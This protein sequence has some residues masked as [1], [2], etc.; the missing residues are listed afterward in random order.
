MAKV[1]LITHDE[2]IPLQF[3]D[4]TFYVRRMA[5]KVADELREKATKKRGELE[6]IDDKLLGRLTLEHCI[7]DWENLEDAAGNPAPFNKGA[8]PFLPGEIVDFIMRRVRKAYIEQG[9][10]ES[11]EMELERKN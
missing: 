5:P 4:T 3:E 9:K 1:Q 7:L 8:I 10:A 6:V 2:R 11:E